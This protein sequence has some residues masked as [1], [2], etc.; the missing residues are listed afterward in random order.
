MTCSTFYKVSYEIL[1]SINELSSTLDY[2]N[3]EGRRERE[4]ERELCIDWYR[5]MHWKTKE[6]SVFRSR[7]TLGRQRLEMSLLLP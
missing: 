6:A 3:R 4:G 1:L 5:H 7:R 2:K